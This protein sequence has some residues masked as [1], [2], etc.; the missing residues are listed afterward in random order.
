MKSIPAKTKLHFSVVLLVGLSESL[1]G[2]L[3]VSVPWPAR[4]KHKSKDII[5]VSCGTYDS[6]SIIIIVLH[7][8]MICVLASLHLE[9]VE[10]ASSWQGESIMAPGLDMPAELPLQ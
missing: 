9:I 2:I 10:L 8:S 3:I 5:M 7:L 1:C 6:M 4:A